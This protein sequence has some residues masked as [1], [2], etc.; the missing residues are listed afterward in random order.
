MEEEVWAVIRSLLPDKVSGVDD[1]S[2][3]FLQLAWAIIQPDIMVTFDTFWHHYTR[4]LN[5]VNGALLTLLP[6]SV[7]AVALKV[8]DPYL[9]QAHLHSPCKSPV[10]KVA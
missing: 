8:S 6:K 10:S 7:E 3:W 9:W 2:A 4:N 5:N 1:F